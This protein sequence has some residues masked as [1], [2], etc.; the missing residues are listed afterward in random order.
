M[1]RLGLPFLI[2]IL[3]LFANLASL[4]ARGLSAKRPLGVPAESII[5]LHERKHYTQQVQGYSRDSSVFRARK[6]WGEAD[7]SRIPAL[8]EDELKS[9]F[10]RVRD[11]RMLLDSQGRARR[12]TWLYPDDGCFARAE[13]MVSRFDK[14]VPAKIFAFGN[15]VASTKN[16][17]SGSIS[18]WYHVAPI[19]KVGNKYYVLDP[20]IEVRRPLSAQEWVGAMQDSKAQIAICGAHAYDPDSAC[21]AGTGSQLTA[22]KDLSRFLPAEWDRLVE[23]NRNP[24]R[25]LGDSPPWVQETRLRGRTRL[26]R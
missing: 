13:M 21:D 23:L 12:L 9:A 24:A 19:V 20:S 22:E 6:S 17:P 26:T 10:T 8:T 14:A 7:W 2:F 1:L 15:L 5:E 3:V 25:E 18:W 16:H 4:E 11:E